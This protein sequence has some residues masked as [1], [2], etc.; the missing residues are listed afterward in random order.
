MQ[1]ISCKSCPTTS[2]FIQRFCSRTWIEKVDERKSQLFHKKGQNIL[3]EGERVLGVHFIQKGKLKV[4]F[5][6]LND[7][8]QIVRF[9]NDGHIIGHRGLGDDDIYPISAAAMED[10]VVCY[11]DN[12]TLNLLFEN[13]S[14][15]VV[16]LMEFYSRELRKAEERIKNLTQM[17][18]R[19]K[20]ADVL[21]TLNEIFGLNEKRELKVT[22]SRLDIACTAGTTIPQVAMQLGELEKEKLI[23]RR[24]NKIIALLNIEGLKKI[25]GDH[26]PHHITK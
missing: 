12:E 19:E 13:N 11:I 9:A 1:K 8:P 7:K 25:T 10:S 24:G 21:L 26:N 18:V 14:R 2:C 22:F 23:E 15:L 5:T 4:F 20:V 6:G 17:N 3:N 16:G